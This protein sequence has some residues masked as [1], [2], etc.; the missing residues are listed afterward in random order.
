MRGQERSAHAVGR[1]AG[2]QTARWWDDTRGSLELGWA[3]RLAVVPSVRR[4]PIGV[5]YHVVKLEEQ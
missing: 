2:R 1:H 5:I 4:G 3:M